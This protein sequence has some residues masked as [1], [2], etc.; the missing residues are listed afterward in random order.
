MSRLAAPRRAA[1]SRRQRHRARA[2]AGPRRRACRRPCTAQGVESTVVDARDALRRHDRNRLAALRAQA[3]AEK[4]PLAMWVDYWEL[5]N[6]INEVQPAEFTAF[7]QRW[8]GTYVE[9]RHAQ[10]LAARAR[11]PPRLRHLRRRVPAL[12]HE[13]RPRG[14]VLRARQ[15]PARRQGRARGRRRRLAGAEGRRRRLRL[16]RRDAA[17]AEA[18]EPG[19]HLEEGARQHRG[20]PAARRAPGRRAR[21]RQRRQRRRR[22][23]RQP[24]PLSGEEGQHRDPHRRRADDARAGA[25]GGERQRR[26]GDAAR[27]IA[28]SARC[29]PSWRRTP[30]RAS[31]GRA[32]SSCSRK[33][34]TSSCAP[35]ASSARAGARSTCRT[36][37][38]RG[39][40][41]PRCAPTTAAPAG[42]R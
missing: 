16:P 20:Q 8:S 3:A 23:R 9:D 38:W 40:C 18:A 2:D 28:G 11:A 33:P 14:H 24:G 10:R 26:G 6:R 35:P 17:G 1:R 19:R 13:R 4:N 21:L 5:T 41:A 22:D 15:R 7:A 12:S 25:P 36:R 39:R 32:R 42:S 37:R 29:P 31:P 27:T 34:P 30:G